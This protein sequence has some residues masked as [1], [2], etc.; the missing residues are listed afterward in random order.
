MTMMSA[1]RSAKVAVTQPALVTTEEAEVLDVLARYLSQFAL[2]RVTWKAYEQDAGPVV[3]MSDPNGR[4]DC[5]TFGKV[6]DGWTCEA[7]PGGAFELAAWRDLGSP[8]AS[9]LSVQAMRVVNRSIDAV[10]RVQ[11]GHRGA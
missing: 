6:A 9:P 5:L 3:H 2:N 8:G 7:A 1:K 4:Y 10:R 11:G